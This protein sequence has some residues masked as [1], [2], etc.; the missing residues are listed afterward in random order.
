MMQVVKA[1]QEEAGATA[2]TAKQ[3]LKEQVSLMAEL[4]MELETARVAAE[5]SVSHN[6]IL[7]TDS[8]CSTSCRDVAQHTIGYAAPCVVVP[9]LA[10]ESCHQ[11]L[12]APT[13]SE[14]KTE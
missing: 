6:T 7:L 12:M 14:S 9:F 10:L 5:V 1:A 2:A 8:L 3:Q 13:K 11:L 4:K